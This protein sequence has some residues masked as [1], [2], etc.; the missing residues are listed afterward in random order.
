MSSLAAARADNFYYPPEWRPEM[1]GISKFQGSKG[2]NQYEQHGIIR[3]EMPFDGWCLKCSQHL[4]KGLRFNAKKE[5]EGKYFTTQIYSFH[6][7]CITC[8]NPIII[9]TDPKNN[10]YDYAS[11]VRKMEHEYE[12]EEEDQVIALGE[13]GD[14][15]GKD[16]S[17][18]L[19]E[20][21]NPILRLQTDLE[22]RSKVLSAQERMDQLIEVKDALAK[23]DHDNNAALR[24]LQRD[25]KRKVKDMYEEGKKYGL[26]N[27]ALDEVRSEDMIRAKLVK[28]AAHDDASRRQQKV[29]RATIMS[30]SIFQ[31]QSSSS[32]GESYSIGRML[33]SSSSKGSHHHEGKD[34]IRQRKQHESMIQLA[35]SSIQAK[36]IRLRAPSS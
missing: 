1:G 2:K 30:Q 33:P 6:M 20:R 32:R 26:T 27:I 8:A 25:K 34:A 12:P 18:T 17:M 23:N 36:D 4:A 3:F 13:G 24:K 9:K 15:L 31:Q 11:G 29:H 19:A 35:R 5:K 28:Y 22:N 21:N 16:S 7:K 14:D 10:T